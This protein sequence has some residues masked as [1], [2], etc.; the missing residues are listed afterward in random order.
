MKKQI[1][2]LFL[3]LTIGFSM[4]SEESMAF[5][6]KSKS[7]PKVNGEIESMSIG[8]K[9]KGH[10]VSN[11]SWK[12][13][14]RGNTQTCYTITAYTDHT[15]IEFGN[16]DRYILTPPPVANPTQGTEVD[17]WGN[18]CD[19]YTMQIVS[20]TLTHWNTATGTWDVQGNCNVW[21]AD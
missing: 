21:I 9:H 6:R 7:K 3:L 18:I 19:T 14:C 20:G 16:G 13:R 12:I 5:G 2:L 8:G 4:F 1:K 15:E 10:S 17:P 11:G